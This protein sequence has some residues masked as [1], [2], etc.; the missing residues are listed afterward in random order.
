MGITTSLIDKITSQLATDIA[1]APHSALPAYLEAHS[2]SLEE[3]LS[4]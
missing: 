1:H 4:E 3:L 2:P